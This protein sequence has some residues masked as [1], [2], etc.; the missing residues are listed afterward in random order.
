[1][2]DFDDT[3]LWRISAFERMRAETGHSGF[4]GLRRTTVLPTTLNAELSHLSRIGHTNDVLDVVAACMR[5][6]ESALILLQLGGLIWPLT[7]F[8]QQAQYHSPRPL[9]SAL[10]RGAR[11]LAVVAVEP[12]GLRAPGDRARERVG[13]LQHYHRLGPLLWALALNAP[14]ATLLEPITGR[15]AYRLTPDFE[16]D[17]ST[18]SGALGAA[19]RRLRTEIASL[20]DIAGWPGIDAERAARLLNGVY[21]QGGLMLLRHHPAARD[22]PASGR[23]LLDWWRKSGR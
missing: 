8:P 11:D 7:L 1:M 14:R 23:R 13:N 20:H 16:V 22:A 15:V 4:A 6:R 10:A 18:L 2:R 5:Q 21:L 9:P 19:L 17:T 12:P 3:T